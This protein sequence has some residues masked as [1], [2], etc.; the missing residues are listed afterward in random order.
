MA[1]HNI[2]MLGGTGFVGGRLAARLSAA[3]HDVVILSRHRERHRDLLVLPTVRLVQGDVHD[4]EFLHQ[5]F[6]GRD[7]V[8]NLVGILNETGRAGR[9]FARA[10]TELAD[11]II[12]ACRQTGV[13]RVLHMSALHASVE[14]PS[15]YLRTKAMGED[16][17]HRGEG[18]DFHV[19]SFRPSVIFGP[20]DSLLNRFAGL[21]RLA[22]G[23]FPLAC[24]EARFQPV[25]VEDVV[26]AFVESLDSYQTFGNR[27]DL[28]GPKVYT[29]HELVG[30]V[31]QQIGKRVRIIPLN[32]AGSYL[33]AAALEFVPG[34]PF[35]LD[36]YRSLQLDSVC[37]RGFPDVFGITPAP[38]E[39]IAPG[40]LAPHH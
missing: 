38:L 33:Q 12:Q 39:E 7:T 26:R 40:Y 35:S 18:S 10:H 6:A 34:K 3:G 8:I 36:N 13:G 15:Q 2:C 9:G 31:A 4:P 37:E 23:F 30:Y 28:C 1:I 21:L 17:M 19:T 22:P 14:A 24:P 11:K 32:A 16:A 20:G 5:Q 29:L 27:Y 25:F